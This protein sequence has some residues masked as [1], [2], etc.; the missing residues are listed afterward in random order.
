MS[1]LSERFWSK[2]DKTG[3]CWIWIAACNPAGYGKFRSGG[4]MR[5]AHRLSYADSFG[6]IPEG[7]E[8]DHECHTPNCVNPAHLRLATRKQNNENFRG[9]KRTSKSGVRGVCWEPRRSNWRA[10]VKHNHRQYSAGSYR[11]IEEA[12]AAVIA[13][14]LEL[15]THNAI[16]RL[17]A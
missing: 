16:D 5:L 12:E 10:V 7:A 3:N 15:F 17:V 14:R 13:K 2:I 11:T 8:I 1:N 6:A 4:S 9:A